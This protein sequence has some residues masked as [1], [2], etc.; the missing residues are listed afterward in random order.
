L[1]FHARSFSGKALVLSKKDQATLMQHYRK[2]ESLKGSLIL[3]AADPYSETVS[4]QDTL[5]LNQIGKNKNML[6]T[7]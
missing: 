2:G 6:K 1:I 4:R 5:F 7:P 3:P